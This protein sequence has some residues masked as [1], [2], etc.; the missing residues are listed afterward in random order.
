MPARRDAAHG[1]TH[2]SSCH[3]TPRPSPRSARTRARAFLAEGSQR[4]IAPGRGR[5]RRRARARGLGSRSNC[6]KPRHTSRGTHPAAPRAESHG[7]FLSRTWRCS[8]PMSCHDNFC[9]RVHLCLYK[10][11]ESCGGLSDGVHQTGV[12]SIIKRPGGGLLHFLRRK[13]LHKS[14]FLFADQATLSR[15][16]S[17]Q[18][19]L[20]QV[21]CRG[22]SQRLPVR[23]RRPLPSLCRSGSLALQWSPLM[24]SRCVA[25]R[26]CITFEVHRSGSPSATRGTLLCT[27]LSLM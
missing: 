10:Q 20:P 11:K 16:S 2:P 3:V 18:R 27:A 26:Q 22:S 24:V 14:S 4:L 8:V 15:V 25:S 12:A 17:C 23:P 19:A 21:I 13:A 6:A 7:L 5:R 9:A 1:A